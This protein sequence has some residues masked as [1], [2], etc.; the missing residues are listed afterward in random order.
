MPALSVAFGVRGELRVDRRDRRH[1][2]HPPRLG[3]VGDVAVGQQDHRGAVLD[4]DRDRLDRGVEAVGRRLGGQHRHRRLAVAAEHHLQQ[5]GLLGLGRHPGARPGALDVADDQRQLGH[6]APAPMVSALS[7]TPGPGGGGHP[8]LAGE[9]G[10]ERGADAG[11]LVL[12]LEGGHPEPLVLAQLVQ[13]VGGRGD[14]VGAQ[15]QR[16]P[17]LAGRGDQPVRQREVAR[18]LPVLPG[19]HRGGR[20]L[21]GDREHL[22]G[23]AERV[24]GLE[25]GDVGVADV[26]LGRE[27]GATG[28]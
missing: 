27:L 28:S 22:G 9:A 13:H 8:E 21:V 5:V 15:E 25:R 17:G 3:A 20:H 19:R 23:L 14:R 6:H 1:V 10:A 2:G 4:R 24:P 12:G 18:D 16:Q 11:D 7:A 26:R